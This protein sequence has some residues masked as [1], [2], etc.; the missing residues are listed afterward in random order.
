LNLPSAVQEIKEALK[1]DINR[2]ITNAGAIVKTLKNI[3][4]KEFQDQLEVALSRVFKEL[5]NEFSEP[6]PED[7]TERY[8]H[9][10]TLI[11]QAFKKIEDATVDVCRTWEIPENTVRADFDKVKTHLIHALLI[12]GK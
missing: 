12:V 10:E 9:Q 8:K 7:K 11:T 3:D 1:T 2:T 4:T 6:L 5:Q